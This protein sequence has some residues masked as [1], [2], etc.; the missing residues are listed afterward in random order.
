MI[1]GALA[2]K[3]DP[4]G[5]ILGALADK[6]DP[7]GEILGALAGISG[8]LSLIGGGAGIVGLVIGGVG[9]AG[10]IEAG[11]TVNGWLSVLGK[12]GSIFGGSDA[13]PFDELRAGAACCTS[14]S[15]FFASFTGSG[16]VSCFGS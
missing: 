1:L 5:E 6:S 9:I 2:D 11:A 10:G 3:S 16:L 4:E 15:G 7:E 13:G 8:L 14:K 12:L